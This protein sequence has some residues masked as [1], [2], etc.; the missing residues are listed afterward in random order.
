MV[1]S[2]F[3]RLVKVRQHFPR[4]RV[5]DIAE[6]MATEMRS[7]LGAAGIGAGRTVGLTA[8]S[9]GIQNIVPLLA[10]AAK[11]VRET[12]ATPVFL[13]AMGSHGGGTP[14]G[15]ADLLESFGITEQTVGA[16]IITC[17]DGREIGVTPG[18]LR[19]YMLQSAF[20]VDTLIPINRVKTHTSFKG[21]IE[22][23][24]IKKL[25][26]GLGG[27]PGA[28]QF[29]SQGK[30]TDLPVLLQDVGKLI[31]EKMPVVGGIAIVEN[32]Y[33]ET[34]VIK[35][36]PAGNM[37]EEETRLLAYSKTLMPALP[38]TQLHALVI[39]EMGK[40]YSGTGMDTNIIG[41]LYIQGE[42]EP[43]DPHMRY[44]AVMDLSE[45]SH[46]NACGIGLADFTT[47]KLVDKI[48][49]KPTYLNCLTST[50]P[51]RAKIP[52]YMDTEKQVLETILQCLSG[53]VPA[54]KARLVVAPNTLFL[55]ECY[56]SEA[57]L[58]EIR[59]KDGMEI[60]GE[61]FPMRFDADGRLQPR[62]LKKH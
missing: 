38:V 12:G 3:P 27:P 4:P 10:A 41:R 49:R 37:L 62:L 61:P 9:R 58:P 19:A 56:V 51:I 42:P 14:A 5:A 54:E 26:V 34:A 25:V 13:A 53:S 21:P 36:V 17:A 20:T 31:L 22:S 52:P 18:G 40:N 60:V 50:F 32:A 8:G 45:E 57:L 47:Q 44:L 11:T 55:E 15:Q 28:R 2:V 48:D 23:G 24:M 35:A 59:A 39:E 29:H 7:L 30:A 46:G 6:T 43:A 33:E 1:E 16:K